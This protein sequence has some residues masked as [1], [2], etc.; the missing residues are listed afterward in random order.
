M[1]GKN[2]GRLSQVFE[3]QHRALIAISAVANSVIDTQSSVITE[4]TTRRNSEVL[5]IAFTQE[6]INY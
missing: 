3:G 6:L 1:L 2:L 4:S 5:R